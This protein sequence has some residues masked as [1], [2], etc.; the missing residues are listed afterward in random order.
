MTDNE[1]TLG[2]FLVKINHFKLLRKLFKMLPKEACEQDKTPTRST[3]LHIAAKQGKRGVINLYAD[4]KIALNLLDSFCNTAAHIAALKR[5]PKF[6]ELLIIKR[7]DLSI[8]NKNDRTALHLAATQL[9]SNQNGIRIF[10]KLALSSFIKIYGAQPEL[11]YEADGYGDTVLHL[12][13]RHGNKQIVEFICNN[14][15][16]LI[17]SLNDK[18][19]TPLHIACSKGYYDIVELLAGRKA[20]LDATNA[21]KITPLMI[22]AERGH[23]KVVELFLTLDVDIRMQDD[24][25]ETALH[26][27]VFNRR[28]GVVK[29]LLEKDKKLFCPMRE[30]LVN[31][32]DV[33]GNTAL[34]KMGQANA[35]TTF[36]RN[37]EVDILRHLLVEGADIDHQN[38]RKESFL[39]FVCYH[40][41]D[42]L[43]DRIDIEYFKVSKKRKKGKLKKKNV[44]LDL[45]CVDQNKNTILHKACLGNNLTTVKRLI[46]MVDSEKKNKDGLTPFLL[47]A[48][49]GFVEIADYLWKKRADISKK[50]KDGKN[51]FH[52]L[53]ERGTEVFSE[54]MIFFIKRLAKE[55]P[56]LLKETDQLGRTP[57]HVLAEFG[58]IKAL[59]IILYNLSMKPDDNQRYVYKRTKADLTAYEIARNKGHNELVKAIRTYNVTLLGSEYEKKRSLF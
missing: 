47:S 31:L 42:H 7:I 39:H 8:K 6:L 15:P 28:D 51:I 2:G 44:K 26:K 9:T 49:L 58:H 25:G 48:R 13:C 1:T 40:G 29:M 16:E 5:K 35:A 27:A 23:E 20:A 4:C 36:Q 46:S 56:E 54:E 19:N 33:Y 57:L 43:L 11:I 22:A 32:L 10:G 3:P 14:A 53:F 12:A 41:L 38:Y 30:R 37:A 52:I 55:K 18:D 50:D 45:E 59:D 17:N 34:L 21:S 24:R